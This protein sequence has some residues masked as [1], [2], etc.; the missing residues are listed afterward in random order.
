M[1]FGIAEPIRRKTGQTQDG[2]GIV[3]TP[4]YLSPEQLQGK[5]PDVRA[6][7]YACGVAFYEIF[8]GVLPFP[9]DRNLMQLLQYKLNEDP[10][11]PSVHWPEIPNELERIIQRSL[12][13]DR[14]DRYDVV[15]SLL[16]D[17]ETLRA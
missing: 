4:F 13:R 15:D 14:N 6:D 9:R 7:I 1:D 2:G 12:A 8:T 17:L 11:P 5:E 10:P 3:G 16:A